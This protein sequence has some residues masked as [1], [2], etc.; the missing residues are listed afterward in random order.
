MLPIISIRTPYFP[1]TEERPTL[2]MDRDDTIMP[3]HPYLADPDA[4]EF[5]PDTCSAL[6]RFQQAGWRLILVSNQSGIGRGIFT[7]G[8]LVA[9]HHRM[10]TM[11]QEG[12]VQLDG[13]YY[14]P[15]APEEECGC[16]KP[17]GGMLIQAMQYYRTNVDAS[18]ML[19]DR[20]G[21]I[22]AG[23]AAGIRAAL[24]TANG[25]TPQEDNYGADMV[26]PS[27]TAAADGLL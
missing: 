25:K 10:V 11:L 19:G 12:G 15:H 23:H 21:D 1:I 16:R 2:F 27:L 4:V 9:V 26:F 13:A 17:Q 14:C 24:I 8:Q 5:Y 22:Q 7:A 6:K 18:I 20:S 3:D